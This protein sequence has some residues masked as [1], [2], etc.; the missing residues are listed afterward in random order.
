[1]FEGEALVAEGADFVFEFV[2]GV[3]GVEVDDVLEAEFVVGEDV[4]DGV[5]GELGRSGVVEDE[6]PGAV[7]GGDEFFEVDVEGDV[8]AFVGKGRVRF[9]ELEGLVE[10]DEEDAGLSFASSVCFGR[11]LDVGLE[12]LRVEAANFG[13]GALRDVEA[14]GADAEALAGPAGGRVPRGVEAGDGAEPIAGVGGLDLEAHVVR[15][16]ER[17]GFSLSDVH[18]AAVV[19]EPGLE[20]SS[21]AGQLVPRPGQG[22]V[23]AERL[24][25]GTAEVVVDWQ[26]ELLEPDVDPPEVPHGRGV[27]VAGVVRPVQDRPRSRVRRAPEHAQEKALELG[28]PLVADVQIHVLQRRERLVT[29]RQR[30]RPHERRRRREE[31]PTFHDG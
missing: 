14:H 18:T 3:A 6:V 26:M 15:T 20:A 4:V 31:T 9:A 17:Q 11:Q 29:H 16:D 13:G 24:D 12:D 30:T 28:R 7:V 27:V 22:D 1:M 2:D 19:V 5:E 21:E 23:A 25:R 10:A 8:G